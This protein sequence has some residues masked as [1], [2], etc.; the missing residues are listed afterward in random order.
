MANEMPHQTHVGRIGNSTDAD[1]ARIIDARVQAI[2]KL[3]QEKKRIKQEI[4][5]R[6]VRNLGRVWSINNTIERERGIIRAAEER[7]GNLREDDPEMESPTPILPYLLDQPVN[8]HE[9]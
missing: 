1:L 2:A 9:S 4:F 3:E 7:S 8:R 5:L 6:R